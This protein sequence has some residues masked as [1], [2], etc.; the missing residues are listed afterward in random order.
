MAVSSNPQI[1]AES[2]F[3][4][5][6]SDA[7]QDSYMESQE[8]YSSLFEDRKK[9]NAIMSTLA[10]MLYLEMRRPGA[11]REKA[12]AKSE[13]GKKTDEPKYA[14]ETVGKALSAAEPKDGIKKG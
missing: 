5:A 7:A 12:A 13:T 3:P 11:K 8:T 10:D 1:F 2:I 4:Q 14:N 6:F 9:Y